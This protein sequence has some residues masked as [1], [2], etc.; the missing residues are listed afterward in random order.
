[1]NEL[2]KPTRVLTGYIPTGEG[3]RA[4]GNAVVQLKQTKPSIIYLLDRM[5]SLSSQ[6]FLKFVDLYF[7]RSWEILAS[8]TFLQTSS[9][10]IEKCYHLQQ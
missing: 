10:Y 5:S 3:L 2:L 1:M 9:P 7:K 8:C 4:V 6:R